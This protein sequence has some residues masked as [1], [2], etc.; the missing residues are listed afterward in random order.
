MR[1]ITTNKGT[2][3]EG[4]SMNFFAKCNINKFQLKTK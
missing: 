4:T 3:T 1:S 2:A